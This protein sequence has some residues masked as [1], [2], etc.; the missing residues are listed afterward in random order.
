MV[1]SCG[2]LIASDLKGSR[3][4]EVTLMAATTPD[5]S[6]PKRRNKKQQQKHVAKKNEFPE[7]TATVGV[8]ILIKIMFEDSLRQRFLDL[9]FPSQKPQELGNINYQKAL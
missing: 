6:Y 8:L 3:Q 9:S 1:S 4:G 7:G 5:A 2:T